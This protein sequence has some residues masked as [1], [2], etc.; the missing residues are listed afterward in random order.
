MK[1]FF[2]GF[3]LMAAVFLITGCEEKDPNKGRIIPVGQNY[4]M[5]VWTAQEGETL[6]ALGR[7]FISATKA[8]GLQ[9]N[10]VSFS[11]EELLQQ[12]LLDKMAEGQGPDVVFTTGEWIYKNKNKLIPLVQ[13]EGFTADRFA[14][15][16]VRAAGESM[17]QNGEIYGV[18][19]AVDSLALIY[20]EDHMITRLLDR[21]SPGE[22]WREFREDTE[23]LTK[24]DNSL[25]RFAVSGAAIGRTDN[26]N[27]GYEILENIMLQMGAKFFTPDGTAAHFASTTGI[28]SNGSRKNFGEEALNFFTSFAK[29]QYK[30]YSWNESLADREKFGRDFNTFIKGKTSMVFGFS[31]DLA[32]IKKKIANWNIKDGKHI[33]EKNIRV[34]FFPQFAGEENVANKMVVAK[35]LGFAVPRTAE[36]QKLSWSFLKFLAKKDIASSFYNATKI[37]TARLDLI[38]EQAS[39][40]ELGFFVRQAKFAKNNFLPVDSKEFKR[41]MSNLVQDV[42]SKK[43]NN[44]LKLLKNLE[45]KITENLKEYLT[46][47]KVI[48]RPIKKKPSVAETKK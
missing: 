41:E 37:P 45:R 23:K 29:P 43:S 33:S 40:P 28:L 42:I 13:S 2:A 17:V 46:L 24:E 6:D 31:R 4:K 19:I 10:V 44:S 47:E 12:T 3:L 36:H 38:T 11:S 14:A 20:N 25:T 48:Q 15:T 18:P 5:Q 35:V 27:Y 1:R 26:L 39:D 8:A 21:N 9:I 7:E 16:F 34:D 32:L 22:T 30:N